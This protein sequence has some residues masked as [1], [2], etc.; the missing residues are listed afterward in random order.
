M[1]IKTRRKLEKNLLLALKVAV[2][3]AAAIYIAGL[4]HLE[5]AVSA[6]T[7]TLLSLLGTKWETVKFTFVRIGTFAITTLLA[8]V[9]IPH[10][11]SVWVAFGMVIFGIVFLSAMLDWKSTLSVN[12]VIAAHYMTTKDF[13]IGFLYNEFMLVLI[14]VSIAFLLNMFYLNR[15]QKKHIIKGMRFTEKTLQD[16]LRGM[17]D[18]LMGKQAERNVWEDIPMLEERLGDMIEEAR[19]YKS[20]S[21][22]AH[23]QYY[24]D[25][26]ITR[27]NQCKLLESLRFE[28]QN[29]RTMPKQA[30]IAA[31]YLCY[32]AERLSEKNTA[33]SEMKNLLQVIEDMRKEELPR[34]QEEFESRALL[35]HIMMDIEEF[36]KYKIRFVENISEK[37]K[38]EYW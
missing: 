32:M 38:K 10:M 28:M 14:G 6:G 36:L 4:F 3:S 18:Y 20:N 33:D 27:M 31:D 12:G 29:I 8:I 5:Y 19:E 34:E 13:S 2:G 25:Y 23:H 7:V 37:Q 1:S 11:N 17:A 22:K 26:F 9:F 15:K 30:G 21:F 35:Y 24:I 16:I